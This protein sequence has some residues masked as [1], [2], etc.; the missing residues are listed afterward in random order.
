VVVP[1][2]NYVTAL[3]DSR[4]VSA[5]VR[6]LSCPVVCEQCKG[7]FLATLVDYEQTKTRAAAQGSPF[8]VLCLDCARKKIDE[9]EL[10]NEPVKH[11][12]CVNPEMRRALQSARAA[13]N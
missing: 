6:S 1:A 9:H 4:R 3:K 7:A 13:K 10:K 5:E 2:L 11:S 12:F 8:V